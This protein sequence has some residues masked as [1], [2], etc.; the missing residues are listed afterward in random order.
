MG[1]PERGLIALDSEGRQNSAAAHPLGAVL[2]VHCS[3]PSTR[4]ITR[5]IK[6]GRHML[7]PT[8][9]EPDRS[10]LESHFD[11]VLTLATANRLAQHWE[12]VP[13]HRHLVSSA[14][15][16]ADM[17]RTGRSG[18]SS[19]SVVASSVPFVTGIT[20]RRA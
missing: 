12:F 13:L 16:P 20:Y 5:A 15:A 18:N 17:R 6:P 19:A 2:P 1:G 9:E 10:L 4:A 3:P 11:Q 14:G 7:E 8:S